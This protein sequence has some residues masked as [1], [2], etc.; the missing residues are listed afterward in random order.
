MNG[1]P[2]DRRDVISLIATILPPFWVSFRLVTGGWGTRI[3]YL[4]ILMT[5]ATYYWLVILWYDAYEK[6]ELEA[7]NDSRAPLE[8]EV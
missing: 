5:V 3:F 7:E 8:D 4:L 2:P 6:S 1:R